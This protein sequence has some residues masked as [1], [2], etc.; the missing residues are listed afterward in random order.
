MWIPFTDLNSFMSNRESCGLC[1][2]LSPMNTE[3]QLKPD[4]S[5]FTDFEAKD[6]RCGNVKS[7]KEIN[8]NWT[9]EA[10]SPLAEGPV[11]EQLP[12]TEP[13]AG[14]DDSKNKLGL[15]DFRKVGENPAKLEEE[16][17]DDGVF[18]S[19]MSNKTRGGAECKDEIQCTATII[20]DRWILSAA[21]CYDDF[22]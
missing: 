18:F 14:A 19:F 17:V 6:F 9:P 12:L 20:N 5:T 11:A 4:G 7:V 8:G 21:H 3:I 22:G 13:A 10:G 15:T 2:F 16:S 1:G